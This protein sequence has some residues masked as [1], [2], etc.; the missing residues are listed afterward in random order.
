M[1]KGAPGGQLGRGC[2]LGQVIVDVV[3]APMMSPVTS[4]ELSGTGAA[5]PCLGGRLMV[6]AVV[7]G[8]VLTVMVLL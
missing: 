3:M 7:D 4:S 5:T 6:S 1:W 2:L 8:D